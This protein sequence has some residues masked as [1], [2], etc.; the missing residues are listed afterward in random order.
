MFR[1]SRYPNEC[2]DTSATLTDDLRNGLSITG[3]VRLQR[4]NVTRRKRDSHQEPAS[5]PP[6][7][8]CVV[9]FQE[10]EELDS[11]VS[12]EYADLCFNL[13]ANKDM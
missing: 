12:Y 11:L 7:S 4:Q 10:I 8:T 9:R 5:I 13:F 3:L 6:R 2:G 1:D